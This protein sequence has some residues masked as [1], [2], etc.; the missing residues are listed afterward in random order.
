LPT[1]AVIYH[2]CAVLPAD[3]MRGLVPDTYSGTCSGFFSKTIA[4]NLD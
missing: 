3:E 1:R 2:A 4:K